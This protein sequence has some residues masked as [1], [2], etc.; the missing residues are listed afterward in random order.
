MVLNADFLLPHLRERM[1]Q[2]TRDASR[3]LLCPRCQRRTKL[4]RLRDGRRKCVTCAKKF[5]PQGRK[6][7]IRLRRYATTLLCFSLDLSARRAAVLTGYRYDFVAKVYERLRQVLAAQSLGNDAFE[8]LKYVEDHD[9]GL[10]NSI[11]CRRCRKRPGCP[12]RCK[13]DP[14]VFGLTR[15]DGKRILLEPVRD[16]ATA[17]ERLSSFHAFICKRRLCRFVDRSSANDNLDHC[18]LWIKERLRRYYHIRAQNLGLYLKE[19]E[20]K[21]NHRSSPSLAAAREIAALLPP[22]F[23][24]HRSVR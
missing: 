11:F 10:E 15:V 2:G 4:Y 7:A 21:Y 19:L 24:S 1:R 23:L 5:M 20:W 12:G 16:D 3:H 17:Q 14:P 6:N 8:L 22:H 13:G 9:R 18:W